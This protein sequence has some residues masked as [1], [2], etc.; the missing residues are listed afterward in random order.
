MTLSYRK[1]KLAR[2]MARE[3]SQILLHNIKDP[4]LGFAGVTRVELTNDLKNAKVMISM[5]GEPNTKKL[6]MHALQSAQGFVQ[7]LLARRILI[8]QCPRIEF[9]QDDSI[10]KAF[11]IT[12][13]IDDL[14]KGRRP[15]EE[16]AEEE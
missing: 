14:S 3:I 13:L 16:S 11:R 10:D 7:R 1:E 12:K 5:M 2:E 9:V 4:R 6:T 8:R 15:E